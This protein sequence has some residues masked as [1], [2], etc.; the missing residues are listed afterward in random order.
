MNFGLK[1]GKTQKS[2]GVIFYLS[3]GILIFKTWGR[4]AIVLPQGRFN[5][6]SDR[7]IRDYIAERCRILAVVGLHGNTFK[8]HTGTKTSVLFVQKWMRNFVLKK[9]IIIYSLPHSVW[10]GKIIV[11]I[12]LLDA[13]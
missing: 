11:G 3:N 10:K 1:N 12:N 4:M 8:P 7:Y 2:V 9:K 5:N 6:S 13:G